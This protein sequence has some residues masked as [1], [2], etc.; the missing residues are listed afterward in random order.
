M[1]RTDEI[2]Y[3]KMYAILRFVSI[4]HKTQFIAKKKIQADM[5]AEELTA[6]EYMQTYKNRSLEAAY[7]KAKKR[8]LQ[9]KETLDYD[10]FYFKYIKSR[11][12]NVM[13]IVIEKTQHED[14]F[15]KYED[16]YCNYIRLRI[17][18]IAK[19]ALIKQRKKEKG[20]Q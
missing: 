15:D 12:R 10:K 19:R 13:N 1:C 8:E 18:D 3:A 11:I 20:R 4:E 2:H 7:W 16:F 14:S 9:N 6:I 17:R 5:L